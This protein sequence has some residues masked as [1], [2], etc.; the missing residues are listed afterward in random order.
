N[1]IRVPADL[2]A[3]V[4]PA[5]D[6]QNIGIYYSFGTNQIIQ[7]NTI[8][9]A[10]NGTSDTGNNIF[11]ASIGI[12][13]NTSGG[14][15]YNGLLIDSNIINVLNAQTADPEGI[16][17]IWENGEANTSN[18]TVSNNQFIS[19]AGGNNPALNRQ[20]AF[21]V[22]SHSSPTTTV[23]YTGNTVT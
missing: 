5:D 1:H 3:T 14:S 16:V 4:A 2:N 11:A 12:Q 22:T 13:S 17:G 19:T 20:S 9:I 6:S 7:G 8:D 10:G 18:I 23:S 21:R 15:V